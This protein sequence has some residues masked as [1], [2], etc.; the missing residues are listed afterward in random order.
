MSTKILVT[1][2]LWWY[3]VKERLIIACGKRDAHHE[4]LGSK[5]GADVTCTRCKQTRRFKLGTS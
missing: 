3:Q 2:Y 5:N 4:L 1:H